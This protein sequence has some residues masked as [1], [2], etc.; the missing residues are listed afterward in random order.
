MAELSQQTGLLHVVYTA[1]HPSL[2]VM[3]MVDEVI[4]AEAPRTAHDLLELK[5]RLE[6]LV[7]HLNPHI[8]DDPERVTINLYH[9]HELA[10]L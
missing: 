10:G 2:A 3:G 1:R 7:R 6:S 5:R 4:N 8:S 9:W